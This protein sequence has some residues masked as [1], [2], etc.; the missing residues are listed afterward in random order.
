MRWILSDVLALE[1]L[2][3]MLLFPLQ[4]GGRRQRRF[5][6]NAR[7]AIR[8]GCS[9]LLIIASL[10]PS[11]GRLVR[12]VVDTLCA[13]QLRRFTWR[14]VCAH[15]TITASLENVHCSR[16][17]PSVMVSSSTPNGM[18]PPSHINHDIPSLLLRPNIRT[19]TRHKLP[20]MR[21]PRPS[22]V[23]AEAAF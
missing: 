14:L 2:N 23:R 5:L 19:I 7:G 21:R 4:T 17:I 8:I 20:L 16:N 1:L 12:V 22:P 18:Q 13:H 6:S 3:R 9:A 10:A 11:D 15:G